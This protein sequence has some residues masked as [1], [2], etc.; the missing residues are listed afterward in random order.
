M[1][2][3]ISQFSAIVVGIEKPDY[4]VAE[5]A[6]SI[7]VC[8]V[9]REPHDDCPVDFSISVSLSTN[10]GSAGTANITI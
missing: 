7:Q 3:L 5:N 4:S 9:I 8:A 2:L 6:R 10:D 1:K